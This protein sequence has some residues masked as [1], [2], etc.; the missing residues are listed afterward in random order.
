[1]VGSFIAMVGKSLR[2]SYGR[3]I[4]S[5]ENN[6]REKF[7]REKDVVPLG[8]GAQQRLANLNSQNVFFCDFIETF[9]PK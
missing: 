3:E 8:Y 5:R 9:L 6:G 1:M 4:D 2:Y 7:I